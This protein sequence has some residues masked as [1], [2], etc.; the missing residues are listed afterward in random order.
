[1]RDINFYSD[2]FEVDQIETI[3][4]TLKRPNWEF[5]HTSNPE[6][7]NFFWYM[8]LSNDKFFTENL[9]SQIKKVTDKNLSIER[10]YANGQTFGLDG[11]FHI[12]DEDE[13]SYTFLYYPVKDWHLA[14]RGETVIVDEEG[15]IH[16][17]Y[18]RPNCAIMFPSNWVHC[19][20]SPSK[21][22]SDLRITIAY[23]LKHKD[24]K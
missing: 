14:W 2:I 21:H 12:D 6:S 18:P 20:R 4:D 1:M 10:V 22:F 15:N 9:F 11:E 8:N 3:S 5:W 7:N 17:I 24:E 19:G 16:T 13:N 23:K